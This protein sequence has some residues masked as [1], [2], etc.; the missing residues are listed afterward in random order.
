MRLHALINWYDEPANALAACIAALHTTQVDHVI[1]VDGAYLLYPNGKA[2]SPPLQAATIRDT[3]EAL[4]IASTIHI[5]RERWAGNEVAKRTLMF[6]LA[7]SLSDPGD[8]WIVTDA[9]TIIASAPPDLKQ[10]LQDTPH[11]VA[12]VTLREASDPPLHLAQQFDWAPYSN[13]PYRMLF[14]AQPMYCDTNHC[15]YRTPDG[16]YL[17]NA[18]KPWLEEQALHL[19]G[20][21]VDH[22]QYLRGVA[23]D[24]AKAAYY[25]RRDRLQVERA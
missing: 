4:N 18:R 21:T 5:P 19:E 20:I 7:W 14:R 23:R 11:D 6:D 16:R 22:R 17:W 25:Q 9:D 3:C 15:T 8:W 24:K 1:A 10:L 13:M 12:S 2:V